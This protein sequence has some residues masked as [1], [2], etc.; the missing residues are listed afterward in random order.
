MRNGGRSSLGST[1]CSD[2]NYEMNSRQKK[3][4]KEKLSHPPN[5]SGKDSRAASYFILEKKGECDPKI[6]M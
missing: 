2:Y 3:N 6:G 5:S 4:E 1:S